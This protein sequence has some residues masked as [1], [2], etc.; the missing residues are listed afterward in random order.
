MINVALVAIGFLIYGPVMLIGLQALDLVPK[1][2]AGT[3]AG[4]T[5][6]FGY[7]FGSF[8]ANAVIGW[9]VDMA[10]WHMGFILILAASILACLIF[11]ATWNVRGQEKVK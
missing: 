3:A 10:G 6:L 5:G 8:S 9:V 4:L 11:L 7:F 2:A 1:K